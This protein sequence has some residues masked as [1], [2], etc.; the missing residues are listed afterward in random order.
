[1][2]QFTQ[3]DHPMVNDMQKS[4]AAMNTAVDFV[5]RDNVEGLLLPTHASSVG[6]RAW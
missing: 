5:C 4:I 2:C 1:M 6:R 3:V